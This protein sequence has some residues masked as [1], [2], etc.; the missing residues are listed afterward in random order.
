MPATL[1]A[2][3]LFIKNA[4]VLWVEDA[5]WKG[6]WGERTQEHEPVRDVA[7]IWEERHGDLDTRLHQIAALAEY[8][9]T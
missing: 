5:Q 8:C 7:G 6:G 1:V 2:I 4:S 9:R 3:F